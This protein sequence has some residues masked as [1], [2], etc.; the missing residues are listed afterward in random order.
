MQDTLNEKQEISN[1]NIP[2]GQ[3]EKTNLISLIQLQNGLQNTNILK[4][5]HLAKTLIIMNA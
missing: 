3:L 2:K 1:T 4:T 5:T